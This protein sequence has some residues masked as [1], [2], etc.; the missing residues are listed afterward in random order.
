[1]MTIIS[2]KPDQ[3]PDGVFSPKDYVVLLPVLASAM[4][5]TYDVGY[6]GALDISYF[7]FFSLSEHIVFA[8]QALPFAIIAAMAVLYV[9]NF[10]MARLRP[11]KLKPS[12]TT[13]LVVLTI[14]TI[15]GAV[16][17]FITGPVSI[18]LFVLCIPI[19][20]A[21]GYYE[22]PSQ[23]ML[24]AALGTTLLVSFGIGFDDGSRRTLRRDISHV[25]ATTSGDLRVKLIRSGES[26]ILFYNVSTQLIEFL[27]WEEIKRITT[28]ERPDRWV[29]WIYRRHSESR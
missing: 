8:I 22:A 17:L 1:M 29:P 14:G 19:M 28:N 16:V 25:L 5:V 2:D 11:L 24:A 13:I 7:S 23:F 6:F 15:V 12:V 4:A 20:F 3:K 26:G 21:L 10:W 18:G 27:R 9:T